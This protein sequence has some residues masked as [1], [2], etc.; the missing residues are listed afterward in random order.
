MLLIY[1]VIKVHQYILINAYLPK[2]NLETIKLKSNN[3]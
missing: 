3:D 1:A 2:L